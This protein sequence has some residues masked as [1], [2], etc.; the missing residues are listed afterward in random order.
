MK[1]LSPF[2]CWFLLK[3][4]YDLCEWELLF[5]MFNE[6]LMD[7]SL[8]RSNSTE[9]TEK[10]HNCTRPFFSAATKKNNEKDPRKSLIIAEDDKDPQSQYI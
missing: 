4:N 5:P 2:V 3:H 6:G 8:K 10:E 7:L 1:N 9:S